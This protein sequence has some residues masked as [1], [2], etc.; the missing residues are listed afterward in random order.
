MW[1]G[2]TDGTIDE[3]SPERVVP[4]EGKRWKNNFSLFLYKSSNQG[5]SFSVSFNT[6]RKL[7]VQGAVNSMSTTCISAFTAATRIEGFANSFGDSGGD[8]VTIFVAQNTGAGQQKRAKKG[9]F[10]ALLL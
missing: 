4:A 5:F 8:A 9:F 3:Q 7:L 6:V 2:T 10:P 1:T